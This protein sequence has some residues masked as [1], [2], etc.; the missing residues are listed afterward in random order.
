MISVVVNESTF[1]INKRNSITGEIFFELEDS[2]FPESNWNDFVV[3]ILTWWNK[4]IRLLES[5]S[6]GTSVD[7][8]FMDGPYYVRA[9][10]KDDI[11]VSL[12]F[13]RRNKA[14]LELITT[15]DVETDSLK[16]SIVKASK[17]VIREIQTKDWATDDIEQLK[18]YS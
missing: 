14:N 9:V 6:V 10:K 18:N 5:S 1:E 2:Y 16:K 7:F 15:L 12:S 17:K 13:I 8:N 11:F 3:V 4:S